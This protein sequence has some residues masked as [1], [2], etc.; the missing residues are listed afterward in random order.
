MYIYSSTLHG[1]RYTA[2]ATRRAL[3]GVHYMYSSTVPYRWVLTYLWLW[4]FRNHWCFF[5]G[6]W[7]IVTITNSVNIPNANKIICALPFFTVMVPIVVDR[8]QFF[9]YGYFYCASATFFY[10]I[11]KIYWSKLKRTQQSAMQPAACLNWV[12]ITIDL[13]RHC[14]RMQSRNAVFY[15]L[16]KC[17]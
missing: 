15:W 17:L 6:L 10:K 2:R 16:K 14:S 13:Q 1:A 3:H 4:L 9:W 5:T 11:T 8:L 7:R 12:R